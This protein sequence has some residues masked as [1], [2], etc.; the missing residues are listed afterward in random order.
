MDRGSFQTYISLSAIWF[1]LRIRCCKIQFIIL[2][3]ICIC[4]NAMDTLMNKKF[5]PAYTSQKWIIIII[6]LLSMSWGGT[7][8]EMIACTTQTR[9]ERLICS[10]TSLLRNH[11]TSLS[12]PRPNL[13]SIVPKSDPKHQHFILSSQC[14]KK[15]PKTLPFN[16]FHFFL[17]VEHFELRVCDNLFRYC[18]V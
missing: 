3:R 6:G 13:A 14:K 9:V 10:A 15:W 12:I 8:G 11:F 5:F 7:S 16:V 18:G 4:Y 17:G 1:K 2:I